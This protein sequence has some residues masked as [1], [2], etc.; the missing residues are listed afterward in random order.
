MRRSRRVTCGE[1]E[2]RS[3][4][5][6]RDN[7]KDFGRGELEA[8]RPE[9]GARHAV[10]FCLTQLYADEEHCTENAVVRGL[11]GSQQFS[12]QFV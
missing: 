8:S 2:K 3:G 5:T 4:Q 1:V 9:V 10:E 12:G 6:G 7:V 11:T